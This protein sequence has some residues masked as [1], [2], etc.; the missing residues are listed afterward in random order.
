MFYE[1]KWPELVVNITENVI[2]AYKIAT[3]VSDLARLCM[4]GSFINRMSHN[5]AKWP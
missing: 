3:Y 2:F 1:T 4:E 5:G